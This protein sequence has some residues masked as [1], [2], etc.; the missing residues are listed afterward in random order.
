MEQENERLLPKG[1]SKHL[2]RPHQSQHF[3]SRYGSLQNR[4]PHIA[5]PGRV[6]YFDPN[7]NTEIRGEQQ[8]R[9][10]TSPEYFFED[11]ATRKTCLNVIDLNYTVKEKAGHWWDR[12]FLRKARD[13]HVLKNLSMTFNKGEIT[14]IVG[15]SGSGKT[16]LLD[17]ISGRAEGKVEGVVSY[18][19]HQ[20][21]R[22]TMRQKASYV[23]QADRLLPTLTVRETL[24]YMALMKL[25]GTLKNEEID[26]KVQKVICDMGLTHVADSRIGGAVVRGVSGGEK[27]RITIGVQLLKDPEILL[28]DE[29]TSGLDSFTARHLVSTL[30]ELAHKGE[31]LVLMTVHQPRSDIVQMLDKIG[32]LTGGQLAYLGPPSQMVPFFT[33]IGYPCPKNQ[34]PCDVYIDIT[35]VDRRNLSR[36]Q[37]TIARAGA[38]CQ[39]FQQSQLQRDI[40]GNNFSRDTSFLYHH[41][42]DPPVFTQTQS[43]SWFRVF[44]CLLE[45]MNVHLW[46][47]RS[48]LVGRFVQQAFFVPFLILFIGR[49]SD[50]VDG[51]Q[52]RLGLIYQG[53]SSAPY[54]ALTNAVAI[55]PVLRETYYRES[56]DGMY[57]T[58]T[59]LAAYYVH[60]LPFNIIS[61]TLF[62]TFL[63]WVVGFKDDLLVFAMFIL[64]IVMMGQFGEMMAV[65]FMGMIRSVQL[66]CDTTSL[67]FNTSAFFGSGLIRSLATMPKVL[68]QIG[69]V[70]IHRYSTET[71]IANEFHDLKLACSDGEHCVY[72]DDF[73][74][75]HYPGALDEINRN[76]CIMG[77]YTL[78]VL[79]IAIFCFKARGIPTLH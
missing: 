13:K 77:G 37:E 5:T 8:T 12:S 21:D 24:T 66:A 50:N 52:D 65:G 29:P 43:P 19:H 4:A 16:S 64:V 76:F 17:V 56:H 2:D 58:A 36:E 9:G 42:K 57:S 34:N 33:S 44:R 15:T 73:I 45:R 31:K 51:I 6:G 46:R 70:A 54:L 25:P 75:S 62:S 1:T 22:N 60:C 32:V 74:D 63:Y 14:A 61:G 39:A 47:E 7:E 38:I 69:F 3:Q 49:V 48:R 30:V 71:V 26:R 59:F 67:L 53:V 72:G 79:G 20:C 40:I 68:E 23:L 18:K 28:L 41:S 27:R 10:T 35:S 55:F 78:A 11:L